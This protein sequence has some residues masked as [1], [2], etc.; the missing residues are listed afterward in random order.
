MI[1]K[2]FVIRAREGMAEEYE[3]RHNPIWKE[4]EAEIKSVGIQNYSIFLHPET[5]YMFCYFEVEDPEKLEHL[6]HSP[7]CHRWWR[8]MTEVLE[9]AHPDAEKG[10]EEELR[11][12][13]HLA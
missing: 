5:R 12:V 1:R 6:A 9:V 7:V 2:A 11:E 4:L 13:F 3:R 10:W 8:Y